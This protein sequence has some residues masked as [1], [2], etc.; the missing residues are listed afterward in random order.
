MIGDFLRALGQLGDARFRRVLWLG[1]GLTL[2]LLVA[3]YAVVLGL[4]SM[5]SPDTLTLPFLGE[6]EGLG[7]LISLGSIL[8]MTALSVFLM[9]PVASAF[10]GLFLEDVAAA[11]EARHYS[12][13]PEPPRL[14]PWQAM[15]DSVNFFFLLVG[16][17]ILALLIYPLAG[18]LVPVVFWAVNGYL[19]GREYFQIAAMRRLGRTG[20]R[21]LYARHWGQVWL[22]GTLMAAPL[23]LPV[24]NLLVPV[25]GAASFTHLY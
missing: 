5:V 11:V 3:I 17:N 4:I 14:S 21:A 1:L 6:V 19:L 8:F 10:T 7:A 12:H 9:I 13:L 22:A 15:I 24:V 20:A 16:V 25:L 23:T 18:P 2:A